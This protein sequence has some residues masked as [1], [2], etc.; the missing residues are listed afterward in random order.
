MK[1]IFLFLM[2]APLLG[3]GQNKTVLSTF[4]ATPKLDKVV[5]F[6]KALANHAQKYHSGDWKWRVFEVQSGPESGAYHITEGPNSWEGM[7]GRGDIS[8]DHKLDWDKNVSPLTTGAGTSGYSQF[9]ADMSTVQLTDYTDKIIISHMYPKPGMIVKMTEMIKKLKKV[10]EASNETVAVYNS[11]N[12]GEPQIATVT[13]L[14]AGLKEL[15]PS[16]RKPMSE[17]YNAIYGAG[18]W[19]YWLADYAECVESRWNEMLFFRADLSS[20]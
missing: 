8:A 11:I 6:E 14:K 17:R 12:S 7:D 19:D 18:T 2:L 20:K 3:A 15:D 13:R 10:W 9:N 5:E 16:F 1:K 4:R